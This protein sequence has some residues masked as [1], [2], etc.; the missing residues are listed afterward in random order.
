MKFVII[1]GD[2]AGMSAASRAKRNRPDMDVIVLEQTEDVSY[3]ACGMPYNIADSNRSMEEL[4][5]RTAPVFR[6]KQGIDLRTGHIAESIDSEAR[7]V[8]GKTR[9]GASFEVSY[10]K[11]L[12]ATGARPAVPDLPGFDLP[13]VMA[14]KSL[15]QGRKIKDFIG[16]NDIRKAVIIGMG[17]IALEM[18]EALCARNVAVEMVKPRPVLLPRMDEQLSS[19]V[20]SELEK[21]NVKLHAGHTVSR[22]KKENELLKVVCPDLTLEGQIVMVAI[23][24]CP[25]VKLPNRRV[26]RWVLKEPLQWTGLS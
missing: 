18:C 19:M 20:Q 12:V 15:E 23:G 5:V 22:I 17:Y 7:T 9:E 2:A 21:N 4:V 8:S 6:E 24:F 26:L 25:T 13:E 10:D 1:G 3:S 11:L 14:L 16:D